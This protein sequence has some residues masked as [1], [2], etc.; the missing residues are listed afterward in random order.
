MLL[1]PSSDPTIC[2]PQQKSRWL[3]FSSLQLSSSGEPVSTAASDF[4]SRLIKAEADMD[5]CFCSPST[6][7]FDV[8]CMLFCSPQLY[9]VL[10]WVTVSFLSAQTSLAILHWTLSSTVISFHRTAAKCCL[11]NCLQNVSVTGAA[12]G[13]AATPLQ[14]PARSNKR[15]AEPLYSANIIN[16][17]C[18]QSTSA[19]KS[20]PDPELSAETYWSL[21]W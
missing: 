12:A 4:Y 3:C 9:R 18:A 11:L 2:K 19:Y 21:V 7:G 17:T 15:A 5:F 6:S 16:L 13:A 10:I 8:L 14:S 1:A 20:P